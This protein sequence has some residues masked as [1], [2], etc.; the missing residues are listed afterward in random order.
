VLK[1]E[2]LKAIKKPTFVVLVC[3]TLQIFIPAVTS[4]DVVVLRTGES[5]E[6]TVGNRETV[7]LQ[8]TLL[9]R[10]TLLLPGDGNEVRYFS[11]EEVAFVFL[12]DGDARDVIDIQGLAGGD[13]VTPGGSLS[14][15]AHSKAMGKSYA[16]SDHSSTGWFVGGLASGV[17]L[18]LI[19]TGV[20]T[21]VAAVSNSRPATV[22]EQV[23]AAC[24][25]DGYSG[26]ARGGNTWAALGG[27]LLGTA[28]FVVV[29]MAATD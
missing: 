3:I 18:G 29:Y 15:C 28:I 6:G 23:E 25:I 16:D 21:I 27:G 9:S 24:Y 19:G 2:R 7:R 14:D 10:I 22:P 1:G 20:I 17:L 26:A 5:I 11:L 13:G 8:P 12:D 4:A